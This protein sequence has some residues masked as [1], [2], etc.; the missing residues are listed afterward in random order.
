MA[1]YCEESEYKGYP[2]IKIFTGKEYKGEKEYIALGVKKA[3]AVCEQ[4]DQI[5]KFVDRHEH[6]KGR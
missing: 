5:R 2:T 6:P 1:S 4:I 3:G